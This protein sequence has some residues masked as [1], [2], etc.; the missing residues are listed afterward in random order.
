MYKFV[1]E[2]TKE[3]DPA[4]CERISIIP[5]MDKDYVNQWPTLNTAYHCF[6]HGLD[7]GPNNKCVLGFVCLFRHV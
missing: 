2:L 5:D 6:Q 4:T 3:V 1:S 7:V